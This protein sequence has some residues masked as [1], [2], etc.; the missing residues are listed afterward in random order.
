[1]ADFNIFDNNTLEP[2]YWSLK[3]RGMMTLRWIAN[4]YNGFDIGFI[5]S[6]KI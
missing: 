4:V 5:A 1:M 6:M 2:F 3:V